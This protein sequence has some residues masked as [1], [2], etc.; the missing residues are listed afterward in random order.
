MISLVIFTFKRQTELL[1]CLSSVN[2]DLVSEVIIFNDDETKSINKK[3]LPDSKNLKVFNP[4]DFGFINREFRKPIYF[5]KSLDIV[6]N[7]NVIC[8][9]DDCIFNDGCIE[10]HAKYLKEYAF[11]AGAIIRSKYFNK[12]SK[13]I[14]QG[15]N[16]GFNIEL[17]KSIG[18]YN[19]QFS[20]SNGGGDPEFWYRLYNYVIDNK[21]PS[22]F[23]KNAIQIARSKQVRNKSFR[24]ISPEKIFE[25]IHGFCPKGRMYNWFPEIRD[26]SKWMTVIN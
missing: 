12:V 25:N 4:Q 13:N 24:K 11:T 10:A 19:E 23:L 20:E 8:S 21:I 5:N 7:K 9:D 26:K 2:C 22:A 18:G 16:Y 3:D 1:R 17:I 15:T 6:S 14:L